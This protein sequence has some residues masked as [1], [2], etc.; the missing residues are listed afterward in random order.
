M[1]GQMAL[2]WQGGLRVR[3]R[4]GD[5]GVARIGLWGVRRVAG[6]LVGVHSCTVL[7]ADLVVVMWGPVRVV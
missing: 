1:S 3:K 7:R 6:P 2:L 4:D 5:C